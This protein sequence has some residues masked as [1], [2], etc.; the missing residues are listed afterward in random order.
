METEALGIPHDIEKFHHYCFI[1]KASVIIDHRLLMAIFKKDAV[2]L[3]QIAKNIAVHSSTQHKNCLQT[4][5]TT[6]HRKLAIQTQPQD[7][8]I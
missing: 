7:K 2:N 1:G 5:T 6:I 4:W 8:K 3:T